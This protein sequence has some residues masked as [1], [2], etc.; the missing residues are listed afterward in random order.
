MRKPLSLA[1]ALHGGAAGFSPRAA[2]AHHLPHLA[3]D[4]CPF[5]FDPMGIPS[6]QLRWIFARVFS[7][8]QNR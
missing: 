2:L 4:F 7:S 8:D 6:M 5:L 3:L 1:A